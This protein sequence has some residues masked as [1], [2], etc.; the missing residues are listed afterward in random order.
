MKTKRFN[1][2]IKIASILSAV[3]ILSVGFASWLIVNIPQPEAQTIGSFTVHEVVDKS[4]SL[5]YDWGNDDNATDDADDATIN[6]GTV[7]ADTTSNWFKPVDVGAEKLS[8]VVAVS[9]TNYDQLASFK[10]E[11]AVP[12]EYTSLGTTLV[13]TPTV[14]CTSAAG[15]ALTGVTPEGTA[16]T[17]PVSAMTADGGS[18][19]VCTIIVTVEFDWGSYFTQGG[20]VVN[21]YVFYNNQEYNAEL[22]ADAIAKLD[23]AIHDSLS[24]RG[25]DLTFTCTG[26]N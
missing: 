6:F 25:Y 11:L 9:I 8:A 15:D 19:N 5:A 23:T 21:P 1:L 24:G 14:T 26:A 3:A 4:V 13:A 12:A 18:G 10:V 22:A 20:E 7:T 2:G 17:V 16:V